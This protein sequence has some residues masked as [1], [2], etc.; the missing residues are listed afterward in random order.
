MP[1][2]LNRLKPLT[3][4]KAKM[5]GRYSDGGGLYLVVKP[6][7]R[8]SWVFL[9]RWGRKATEL[10]LG[11]VNAASLVDARVEAAE[12]RKALA[13][14]CVRGEPATMAI[15][16]TMR[17]ASRWRIHNANIPIMSGVNS[18]ARP[19]TSKILRYGL[20]FAASMLKWLPPFSDLFRHFVRHSCLGRPQ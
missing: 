15:G 6:G 3:V 13:W 17:S 2:T 4:E 9:Y 12:L 11:S 19:V 7:P 20:A 14:S 1:R 18:V 16:P 8:R 5:P 10:G